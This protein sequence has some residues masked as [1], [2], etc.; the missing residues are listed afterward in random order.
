M[1]ARG[2]RIMCGVVAAVV[3][4]FVISQIDHGS[5]PSESL[6]VDVTV[7]DARRQP[8]S[9]EPSFPDT[10]PRPSTSTSTSTVDDDVAGHDHDVPGHHDDGGASHDRDL[11]G[12]RRCRCCGARARRADP[13]HRADTRAGD[14]HHRTT[15]PADHGA[16]QPAPAAATRRTRPEPGTPTRHPAASD[17]AAGASTGVD[18][19]GRDRT[20]EPTRAMPVS[21]RS[22]P[23]AR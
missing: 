17:S 19:V 2:S 1:S 13:T 20:H 15:A 3:V 4:A 10:P 7:V 23:M 11:A 16:A 8:P 12:T 5:L 22:A 18:I 21:R 6:A 9:G 14:H